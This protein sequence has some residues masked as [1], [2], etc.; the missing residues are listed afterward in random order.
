MCF[1]G[2]KILKIYPESVY[3]PQESH[4]GSWNLT[5]AGRVGE[6]RTEGGKKNVF[7]QCEGKIHLRRRRRRRGK[8]GGGE[9]REKKK[10][11]DRVVLSSDGK[12]RQ[13]AFLA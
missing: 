7:G 10:K 11:I 9:K 1:N 13:E 5:L 3:P 8:G 2:L 4:P 6:E 12:S